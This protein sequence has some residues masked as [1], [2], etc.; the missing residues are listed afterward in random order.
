MLSPSPS[1]AFSMKY[2]PLCSAEY[3]E[4]VENCATCEAALV[5]SL[6]TVE[7]R[8]N[9]PRLLWSG[10][11]LGEFDLVAGVLS[12][13]QIPARTQRALGGLIGSIMHCTSAIHVLSADFDRALQAASTAIATRQTISAQTEICYNCSTACS[14]SLAT[15]PRC[16]AQL[17]A[18][19]TETAE[20]F[21]ADAGSSVLKCCPLCNAEYA[22]GYDRC[23]V[24]GVELVPE[25]LRGRPLNEKER[26]EP[27]EAVWRGGDP[28][29][30][31][32]VVAILREAGIRHYIQAS[33]DH[34]VFELAMPRPK[35]IVRV[36]QSDVLRVRELLA[37]I[38]DSPF[39]GAEFDEDNSQA[40]GIPAN[41]PRRMWNP[42][43]A[44]AE[45]LSSRD[46][47]LG[48][49]FEDCLIENRIPY[50]CQGLAPGMLRYFVLPSDE[51]QAR[52]ILREVR[53][54]TPPA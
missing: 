51:S 41:Q 53:E 39:F 15:C 7:V 43:A 19:V 37:G 33:S 27:I 30:V 45:I 11:D 2:C 1:N 22:S 23:T 49:L 52:E 38:E 40:V 35:Y 48:K 8:A 47:A 25:E 12:E 32:N 50:R 54:S 13:T 16:K 34:L 10:R 21:S 14:A 5:H 42:G 24:C 9:P 4:T 26:K 17:I 31:S 18:S 46:T 20:A 36:F 29:A 28:A 6:Q 44:V 3:R